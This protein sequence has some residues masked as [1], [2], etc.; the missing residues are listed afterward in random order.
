MTYVDALNR[1]LLPLC[2]FINEYDTRTARFRRM[3]Q[4]NKDIK[5][6]FN[7]IAKDKI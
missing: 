4:E 5:K 2:I 3:Q 6:V 1:K 7:A